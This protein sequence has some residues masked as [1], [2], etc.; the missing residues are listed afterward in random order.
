[1]AVPAGAPGDEVPPEDWAEQATEA[2][3]P[4]ESPGDPVTGRSTGSLEVDEADLL[5]QEQ[6]VDLTDDEQ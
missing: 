2:G 4:A 1:M 6:P 5:D 3:P